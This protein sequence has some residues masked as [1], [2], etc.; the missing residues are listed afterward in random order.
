MCAVLSVWILPFCAVEADAATFSD[1]NA[2][3]VFVK[4]Q[5]H[6]TC[7]LASAVMLLRR[8]AMLRGDTDW[9]N[10]TESAC[11]PY[12]WVENAGLYTTFKYKN[13]SV[14]NEAIYGSVETTLINLLKKHPEGIIA[15]DKS[16]P[17][18]ILLTDYTNGVFYCADPANNT[19]SGRIK[20]TQSLIRIADVG[21]Y[22][23]VT[24]PGVSLSTTV[25]SVK[26]TWRITSTNGV[27]M[28][29][30]ADTAASVVGGVPYNA[31]ITVTRK[32]TSGGYTWGYTTYNSV[33]GWVVLDYAVMLS[34]ESTLTNTSSLSATAVTLS[35]TITIKGSATGGAGGYTYAYYYKKASDSKW[36]TVKDYST[37][38]SVN[39][40]PAAAVTYDVCVKVKDSK[41]TIVSSYLTFKVNHIPDNKSKISASSILLG[42]SITLT[43]AASGG[44][45]PYKFAYYIKRSDSSGW[46]TIKDFSTAAAV[47]YRP[48]SEAEYDICI[49]VKDS[50]GKEVRKYFTLNVRNTLKNTSRIS[51]S[52]IYQGSTVT[53]SGAASG[54][55][56]NYT[57]AYY[58][59]QS[60]NE[61]WY[62][63]ADY[64]SS[65]KT[66]ITPAHTGDYD[67]CIKV[68][69]ANG[70]EVKKYFTVTVIPALRN[71]SKISA[72]QISKGST[73]I[74]TG[75]ASGGSGGYT[76]AYYYKQSQNENW[77]TAADY[78]TQTQTVIT[79][80]Y[81]GAYDVC[82]KVKDVNGAE[83]KKYFT[84][85]VGSA[86]QN[87]SKI[88]ASQIYKGDTMTFTGA[89][90]GGSGNYT[91]AYYYKKSGSENW[92]TLLDFSGSSTVMLTVSS[93]GSYDVCIKVQDSVGNL[94]KKYLAFTVTE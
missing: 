74:L 14:D 10:I 64:S 9:K 31:K 38:T 80:A 51:A 7:T 44:T 33:S 47:S 92:V 49:K 39:V 26:E 35:K 58:Y 25:Q 61:D 53:L 57:Y 20:V 12:L 86:L 11:R 84:L 8:T 21:A 3:S 89:A 40:R 75:A 50:S 78:S 36:Y 43:G 60:R 41:G 87:K 4:Q 27:N 72:S 91:Y 5:Y 79:P 56:G 16:Y 30:A 34:S 63:A 83:V 62:T 68:K 52:Q 66:V 71:N 2:S 37:T 70:A 42:Q 28:R 90:S 22:W 69:D 82:I 1:I 55:G 85:T 73:V 45:S 65:T 6:D 48:S 32:T 15:Y 94:E 77:Y 17:H 76:Y 88:S 81:S 46:Y 59:K 19:P 67:V 29:S 54:G 23:Y 24:S 18:A 13:I 93:A